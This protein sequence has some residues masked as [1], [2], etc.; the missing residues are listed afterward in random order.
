VWR[1]TAVVGWVAAVVGCA[2]THGPAYDASTAAGASRATNA[3]GFDIYDRLSGG[4]A[5]DVVWS[6]ISAQVAL[7]MAGAGAR[8]ETQAAMAR[9]LHLDAGR[10]NAA[11]SA[12][13][14]MLM[15]LNGRVPGPEGVIRIADRVWAQAGLQV[16]ADYTRLLEGSFG[17]PVGQVDFAG[18]PTAAVSAI[19]DWVAAQTNGRIAQ[20]V[21]PA[22][23]PRG[24]KLIL[25]NAV[26]LRDRWQKEFRGEDTTPQPFA[27]DHGPVRVSMMHQEALFP[28][29]RVGDVQVVELAYRSG[30]SMVVLLPDAPDGLE[31]MERG[32]GALYEAALTRLQPRRVDLAL[33]RW[34]T[35]MRLSLE[36]VLSAAGMGV[37][38]S[39]AADL[40]GVAPGVGLR[41]EGVIQQALIDVF[42]LGTEAAAATGVIE[43]MKSFHT[44]P[45]ADV[46]FHADHPFAYVLRDTRTGVVLF[47]GRLAAPAGDPIPDEQAEAAGPKD[48][49]GDGIPD[50]VDH[51]PREAEDRDGFEDADGCPDPDND[52]DGVP[53]VRDKCPNEP[54]NG[55]GAD[56][57]CPGLG[58]PIFH[59]P[60]EISI[61]PQTF[62]RNSATLSAAARAALD[63][64]IEAM[65]SS[66]QDWHPLRVRAHA[67]R[68]ERH[69]AALAAARARA[70]RDYVVSRGIDPRRVDAQGRGA[71][72]PRCAD[73]TEACASQNR[74]VEV[75]T[76]NH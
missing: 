61:D 52:R 47:M 41:I 64:I 67:D 58:R 49:D 42:E 24:T 38:F 31:R 33:P 70:V 8:G 16:N 7:V 9:T 40:S 32:L 37:A 3:F 72:E 60:T 68:T 35:E 76:R 46:V 62:D 5:G 28:Y 63:V 55:A 71:S 73:A 65:R 26:V 22:D 69:P 75:S 20:L 15:S 23:L 10:L 36:S 45:P 57:G 39:D 74:R 17:A 66:G 50:S 29:A 14:A 27:T 1:T 43:R 4:G 6:P 25:T 11:C 18:A 44:K 53:D 30:L 51:C 48:T 19:N 21:Q 34:K 2:T 56:I 13:G 54:G 12:F 59:P